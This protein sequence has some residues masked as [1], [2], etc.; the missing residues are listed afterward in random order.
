MPNHNTS[1]INRGK[2]YF[3]REKKQ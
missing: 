2:S 3:R 1:P